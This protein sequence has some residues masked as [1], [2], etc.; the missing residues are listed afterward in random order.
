M[1][2]REV[3]NKY[4]A[5]M[6]SKPCAA[7]TAVF[8]LLNCVHMVFLHPVH[9]ICFRQLCLSK[10]SSLSRSNSLKSSYC[11]NKLSHLHV[12][13]LFLLPNSLLHLNI[14]LLTFKQ[15]DLLMYKQLIDL[16]EI[17]QTWWTSWY[18][19]WSSHPLGLLLLGWGTCRTY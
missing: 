3:Q 1:K 4:S 9:C 10:L 13:Q 7:F 6:F 12:A 18:R 19:L 8:I 17:F 15:L 11:Y 2:R 16:C 5:M 14:A